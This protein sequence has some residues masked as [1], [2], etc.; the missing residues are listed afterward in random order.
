MLNKLLQNKKNKFI[1][2]NLSFNSGH[3][4]T[5]VTCFTRPLNIPSDGHPSI[6]ATFSVS[7]E[8]PLL[9][10]LI[11]KLITSFF[12]DV[13]HSY[14]QCSMLTL[15]LIWDYKIHSIQLMFHSVS[16]CGV[17]SYSPLY[18]IHIF[19]ILFFLFIRKKVFKPSIIFFFE[20]DGGW[21]VKSIEHNKKM[22]FHQAILKG[23]GM[24]PRE[25]RKCTVS[26]DLTLNPMP[27]VIIHC[28]AL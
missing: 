3:L 16:F 20:E 15:Q 22:L 26:A 28:E 7:V 13:Q 11:N 4:S 9:A 21:G 17:M 27:G 18:D 10:G 25:W 2:S 12:C 23:H 14:G 24:L 19:I 6:M 8:W 5:V 1:Q